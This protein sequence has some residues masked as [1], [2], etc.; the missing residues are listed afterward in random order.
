MRL[1]SSQLSL[2]TTLKGH[3]LPKSIMRAPVIAICHGGG[4]M[5]LLNDPSH[6]HIVKSL[7]TRVPAI[8]NLQSEHK[9]KAI[10]LLT[11]HWQTEQVTISSGSKHEMYYDYYGFPPET[12]NFKHDAPGEP[13]VAQLVSK[14]LTEAGIKSVLDSERGSCPIAQSTALKPVSLGNRVLLV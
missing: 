4:P 14:T 13:D 10:I 5:P 12:Y 6:E 3:A 8:L 11:A 7:R 9:P 2:A 1:F